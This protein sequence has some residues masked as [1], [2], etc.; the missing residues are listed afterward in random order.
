MF[1]IAL[2][3][4]AVVLVIILAFCYSDDGADRERMT[5]TLIRAS[6][7]NPKRRE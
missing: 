2:T 7:R 3:L 1:G 6:S 4:V 5:D